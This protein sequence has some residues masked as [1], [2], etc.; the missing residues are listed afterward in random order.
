MLVIFRSLQ[1]NAAKAPA[2]DPNAAAAAALAAAGY[3]NTINEGTLSAEEL[4]KKNG[5]S[6]D[7]ALNEF[8]SSESDISKRSE[9]SLFKQLS[10][11]YLL[12]YNKIFERKKEDPVSE[13]SK[14]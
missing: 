6:M 11:R 1:P 2:V 12:N 14:K 9:T 8:E 7:Q 4:A 13:S 3:G 10:N 5:K